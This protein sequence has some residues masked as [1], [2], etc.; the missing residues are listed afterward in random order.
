MA[1]PIVTLADSPGANVVTSGSAE[2][3]FSP[4]DLPFSTSL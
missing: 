4:L 2:V 1:G 3:D